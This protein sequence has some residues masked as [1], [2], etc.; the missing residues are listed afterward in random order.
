MDQLETDRG[1]WYTEV[2]RILATASGLELQW[3]STRRHHEMA[4]GHIENPTFR[5]KE[6]RPRE[7]SRI[8]RGDGCIEQPARCN[9]RV[10][11]VR[12]SPLFLFS[13]QSAVRRS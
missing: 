4:L 12:A 6:Q 3:A 2:S 10:E 5:S 8:V 11:L 13:R 9:S 1:R 7:S